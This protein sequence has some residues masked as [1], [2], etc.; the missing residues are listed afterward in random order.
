MAKS[1]VDNYMNVNVA[2]IRPVDSGGGQYVEAAGSIAGK[3]AQQQEAADALGNP[4]KDNYTFLGTAVKMGEQF[5]AAH[6]LHELEKK[7]LQTLN[8]TL[9]PDT[10][11]VGEDVTHRK[12]EDTNSIAANTERQYQYGVKGNAASY[13]S[14]DSV[15]LT[16]A[17]KK[18]LADSDEKLKRIIN[19]R[20]TGI[21][22]PDV[23]RARIG[24]ELRKAIAANPKLAG[25][26]RAQ[27]ASLTGVGE[28][29]MEN[30]KTM[31]GASETAKARAIADEKQTNQLIDEL[32]KNPMPN[33][34][35]GFYTDTQVT[36]WMRRGHNVRC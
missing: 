10:G 31:L 11:W 20:D 29:D 25:E 21:L 36:Q 15:E 14:E 13:V 4:A 12:E 18:E 8:N 33:G 28:L 24:M 2:D 6:T 16:P 5:H 9:N 26:L 32:R 23:A 27:T 34:T 35:G 1:S 19:A 17:A 7:T 30:A 22:S 3:A